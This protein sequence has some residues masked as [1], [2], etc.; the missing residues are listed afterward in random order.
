MKHD[1]R[2]KRITAF[3]L[4]LA[5]AWSGILP[6]AGLSF[7]QATEVETDAESEV[8]ASDE[9]SAEEPELEEP[10]ET[11]EVENNVDDEEIIYDDWFALGVPDEATEDDLRIIAEDEELW[12]DAINSF[13]RC[14]KYAGLI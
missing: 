7:V 3:L 2:M 11:S 12:L 1:N 5:L 4:A 10:E 9:E 8:G 14:A 13:A 6:D